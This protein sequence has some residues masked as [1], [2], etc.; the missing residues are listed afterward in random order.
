VLN[1]AFVM[2][3][4]SWCNEKRR[5]SNVNKVVWSSVGISTA[6]FL[7]VAVFG[8]MAFPN[9]G[10]EDILT[11]LNQASNGNSVLTEV[12]VYLFPIIAVASSIPV[13][14]IIIRYNLM[15]NGICGKLWANIWAV[16]LPWVIKEK[17]K[18][19]FFFENI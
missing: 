6:F 19:V 8:A 4:P 11:K 7:A 13:F 10:G 2:T 3:V 12:S 17:K 5:S 16:V 1:Y 9:L 18:F 15:E 14:S